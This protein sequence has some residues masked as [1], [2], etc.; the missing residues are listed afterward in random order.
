MGSAADVPVDLWNTFPPV[1]LP[2]GVLPPLIETYAF[3][4]AKQM[5]SDPAGLAMSALAVCATM[6]PDCIKLKPLEHSPWSESA[7]LWVLLVGEVSSMKTPMMD[8]ATYEMRRIDSEYIKAYNA[9]LAEWTEA[10]KA[11]RGEKPVMT[12]VKLDDV[13]IEKAVDIAANNPDGLGMYQDEIQALFGSIGKYSSNKSGNSDRGHWLRS[14]NGQEVT[15]DRMQRGTH[16]CEHFGLSVLGGIQPNKVREIADEGTDDGMLQR[17]NPVYLQEADTVIRDEPLSP[18]VQE[19]NKLVRTLHGMPRQMFGEL[20]FTP[21]AREIFLDTINGS[22]K[23]YS[24]CFQAFNSQLTAHINKYRGM[25]LRL[26]LTFHCIENA[27]RQ[28]GDVDA[29]TTRRAVRFLLDYLMPH[30]LSFYL[31]VLG[32]ADNNDRLLAVANYILAHKPKE[33][34]NRMIRS[35]TQTFRHLD[36]HHFEQVFS[37]LNAL[38]WISRIGPKRAGE[39]P[40]WLVNP[41]V[42]DLYKTRGEAEARRRE[43]LRLTMDEIFAKARQER[44]GNE[45]SHH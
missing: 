1:P 24:S 16:H 42:Y 6:I 3:E 38:G 9:A 30:A 37:Q 22:L 32:F 41:M 2:R 39:Q 31:H 13:T 23:R 5:G 4:K 44:K 27:G 11:E 7:R 35:G 12:R 25:L 33:L 18:R 15:V 19:Y 29:D 14:Y 26:C 21:E 20:T 34:T 8:D 45:K 28:L 10:D 17:M 36:K 43:T 40:T